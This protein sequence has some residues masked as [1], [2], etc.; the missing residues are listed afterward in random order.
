V[1]A[2]T[3]RPD[4]V[5][6]ALLRPGRFDRVIYVPL[7]DEAARREIL[8]IHF[9]GKPLAEDVDLEAIVRET[10]GY[11]GADL[12]AIANTATMIAIQEFLERYKTPEEA[13]QHLE[14][15][16]ISMRHVREAMRKV[17]PSSAADLKIYEAFA[18]RYGEYGGAGTPS[19]QTI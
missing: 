3:N 10:E 2:A 7:P 16:K 17:K 19:P 1:I 4:I 6:P 9:K 11:S 8:K 12:A 18:K 5:D 13:K 15:L 14:E